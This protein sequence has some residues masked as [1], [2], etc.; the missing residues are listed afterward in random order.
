MKTS[1]SLKIGPIKKD[2]I[3]VEQGD[4]WMRGDFLVSDDCFELSGLMNWEDCC[5]Y[6]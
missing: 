1:K 6:P 3:L 4:D 2:P 5:G